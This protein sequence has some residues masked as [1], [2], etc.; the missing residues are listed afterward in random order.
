M[1]LSIKDEDSY[2]PLDPPKSNTN[3][4]DAVCLLLIYKYS[5]TSGDLM[6]ISI[7]TIKT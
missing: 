1:T 4:R 7:H 6:V 3:G 5:G 2:I